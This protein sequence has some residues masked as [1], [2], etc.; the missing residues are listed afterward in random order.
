MPKHIRSQYLGSSNKHQ[1]EGHLPTKRCLLVSFVF[2][3][4]PGGCPSSLLAKA[5]EKSNSSRQA[6]IKGKS[7]A[8]QGKGSGMYRVQSGS[9]ITCNFGIDPKLHKEATSGAGEGISRRAFLKGVAAAGFVFALGGLAACGQ[10]NA[11][12]QPPTGEDKPATTGT[13]DTTTGNTTSTPPTGEE[14]GQSDGSHQMPPDTEQNN[15]LPA[16]ESFI[17]K[18]KNWGYSNVTYLGTITQPAG[19]VFMYI[20]ECTYPDGKIVWAEVQLSTA[21]NSIE[22]FHDMRFNPLD[23]QN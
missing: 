3:R 11:G 23:A 9:D 8:F 17:E 2:W 18:I 6:N 13:G 12:T 16:P 15:G 14:A 19:T 1:A 22:F 7:V 5:I 10:D 21:D 20:Y 4:T